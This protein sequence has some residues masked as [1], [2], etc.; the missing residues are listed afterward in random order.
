MQF[1]KAQAKKQNKSTMQHRQQKQ[2]AKA[3]AQLQFPVYEMS[4][5]LKCGKLQFIAAIE[6]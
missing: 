2:R 6:I 5:G 3:H 1:Y 4:A